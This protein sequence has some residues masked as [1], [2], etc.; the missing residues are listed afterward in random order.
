MPSTLGELVRLTGGALW[1]DADLTITGAATLSLARAGE[2]TLADHPDR[3]RELAASPAAAV[4]AAPEVECSGK[5]AIVVRDVHAAFAAV[6]A[7]FRPPRTAVRPG[8]SPQAHVSPTARIAADVDIHPGASIGEDVEIGAGTTIHAGVRI[9]PGCVVGEHVTLF[10]NVVLYEDT[11]IGNRV[12]VHAGAVIGAY[13]FGY[14]ETDGRHVLSAQLGNVEIGHDVEIGACATI[15]R[16]TYGPTVIG[17]GTKIDNLVMIAH[18]CRL[19]RHNLICSQVGIAG[20]TTTGDYVVMAGQ[21]GVRDHV[22]IGARAVLCS[23][24]GVSNDVGEGVEVLGSP[25]AP[26]RQAKLQMAAV[27]K[28]PEMRRQFRALQRQ[29]AELR[30]E[31]L[32][33]E[34]QPSHERAA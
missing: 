31:P 32:A 20:S 11:R 12:I 22:H 21:G 13:G 19:G 23:K 28:L 10:P 4:I 26:L 18:N 24:A 29:L 9:L 2:I 8:V 34:D 17:E 30:G 16:G 25:A 5:P 1:G 3:D 27:A 33:P 6:V 14:R 15:D 7:H